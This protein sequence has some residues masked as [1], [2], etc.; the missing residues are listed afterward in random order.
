V[1]AFG[2]RLWSDMIGFPCTRNIPALASE[3]EA[4]KRELQA[5]H[6]DTIQNTDGKFY[7]RSAALEV[8]S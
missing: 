5:T 4:G 2:D 7:R 1:E 8:T 3:Y 6:S